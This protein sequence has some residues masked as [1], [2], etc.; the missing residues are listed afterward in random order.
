MEKI[1]ENII[2]TAF[3]QFLRYGIR[4]VSIDDVCRELRMSKKTFYQYFK[5]KEDLIDA[6]IVYFRDQNYEKLVKSIKDKNAI[7]VLVYIIR[8]I[9]KSVAEEPVM[10]WHD[11]KKYYPALYK[12]HDQIK[13]EQI[14]VGFENNLRQGIKEG[15]YRKNLDVELTSFF[16]SVQIKK[17][18]EELD[19]A[20][21]KY[22]RKRVMEFL[23]DMIV[24]LIANEEGLKYIE[25][26]YYAEKKDN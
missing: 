1:I 3:R 4:N 19:R 11:L 23:I 15:V 22:S 8:E 26:N 16:H 6:S 7:E 2:N 21:K 18:F 24:H 12:K 14:R 5:K 13:A 10:F 9:R 17:T 20:S 25:E